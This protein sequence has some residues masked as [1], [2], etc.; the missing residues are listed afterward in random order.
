MHDLAAINQTLQMLSEP[1]RFLWAFARFGRQ[2]VLT[3]SFGTYSAVMLH[4]V[5]R[6]TPAIPVISIDTGHNEATRAFAVRLI[7][8]LG[9]TVDRSVIP[10]LPAPA[11]GLYESPEDYLQRAKVEALEQALTRHHAAAWMSGVQRNET[12]HRREFDFLMVRADGLYKFHPLLDW[13]ARRLFAYCQEHDLPINDDYIDPAKGR[14]QKQ[15]CGIH[16]TG[17]ANESFTSSEL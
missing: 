8:R 2:L 13:D 7:E 1:E 3:T 14:D 16:L 5:S 9:L 15:E 4:M 6:W 11:N 17:L 10:P 12:D